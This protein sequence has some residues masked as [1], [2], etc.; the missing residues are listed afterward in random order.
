MVDEVQKVSVR[1]LL[2][3][4]FLDEIYERLH[5]VHDKERCRRVPFFIDVGRQRRLVS[6]EIIVQVCTGDEAD[7]VVMNDLGVVA[8]EAGTMIKCIILFMYY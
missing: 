7:V 3:D 1:G 4:V 5:L 6:G 8:D 2:C